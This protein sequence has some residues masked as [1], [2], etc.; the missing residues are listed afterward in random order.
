M[1]SKYDIII[2][3]GGLGGLLCGNILSRE[4]YHVCVLEQ[5][6]KPGGCIQS[7]ARD[8]TIFNTGLNYTECLGEGQVL[9]TYFKYFGIMDKLKIKQLDIACF[10]KISFGTEEIE[11]PFAQGHD[12][13]IEKLSG[14]FP[15]SRANIAKYLSELKQMTEVFPLYTFDKTTN[16]SITEESLQQN[17]YHYLQSVDP[18]HTL[19]QVL[20]GMNSLYGGVASKTPLYIHALINYSFIKSAWRLVDG[21][22]HMAS[23]IAG[24]IKENGGEIML[25][26]RVE[27]IEGNNNQVNSVRL[28]NGEKLFADKIISNIHPASTLKMIPENLTKKN[29]KSRILSLD[30]TIG[31][32]TIYIV[33]KKNSFPYI[34]HNFHHF[35]TKNVWTT[36]YKEENWPEHYFL[37]TPATSK[38]EKWADGIIAMSYMRYSEVKNWENTY[39]ENRGAEYKEFKQE[40]AE[41]LIDSIEQKFPNIRKSIYKYYTST[42]LTYRDYT[43]TPEGSSYGI[44]K[45]SNNPFSTIITPK[46]RIKN[47][48]YTGQNLNLHGILG[49]TIGAVVTCSEILGADYLVNKIIKYKNG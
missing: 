39:I 3:G 21:S 44:L 7:F 32:F 23:A 34:N 26:T 47:L 48:Y 10:N 35:K 11:Y 28:S 12:N 19:Q 42:P 29:Y 22:S 17:T 20:A 18:D 37:Y 25:S 27:A 1:S 33:L 46:S 41:K 30:N 36:G 43:G 31:M 13:F 15:Q 24:I 2:I 5:T 6:K 16:Q 8:K 4:G 9:N 40:K 14:F 38:S 45:D 49:V